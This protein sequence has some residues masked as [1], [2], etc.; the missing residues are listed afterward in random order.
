MGFL[1]QLTNV[2][3]GSEDA[4]ARRNA[5]EIQQQQA[6]SSAGDLGVAGESAIARFNPLANVAQAGIEQAGFLTD[7]NQQFD[8]IQSNPLFQMGLQNA[9]EQI[10][11]NAASRGRLTAGDTLERLTQASTLASQPLIDR[12]RQDILNL[13]NL[14]Q[15][16][17][18]QQAGI[19]VGTAQDV[20]NLLTGGAA[21][22]AAGIVGAQNARTDA[23][24]NVIDIAAMAAG[25]PPGTFTGGSYQSTPLIPDSSLNLSNQP[26]GINL[27]AGS[28]GG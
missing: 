15:G 20:A 2:F 21:S 7:P 1:S 8:F 17:T 26:I 13:L 28:F 12:Q 11:Q 14:S 4:K 10:Q 23:F 27:N 25:A 22:K 24:G 16:V 5:G 9:N 6:I 3:T 18:G 19:E